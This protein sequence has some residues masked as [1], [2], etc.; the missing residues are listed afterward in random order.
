MYFLVMNPFFFLLLAAV[1]YRIVSSQCFQ[2]WWDGQ[3]GVV[4]K[5]LPVLF[6]ICFK[7]FYSIRKYL[8]VSWLVGV[9]L[10][11]W[12]FSELERGYFSLCILEQESGSLSLVELC[13]GCICPSV[14][15]KYVGTTGLCAC[16]LSSPH[17]QMGTTQT[18]HLSPVFH[19]QPLDKLVLS[20]SHGHRWFLLSRCT[21]ICP[22]VI[23]ISQCSGVLKTLNG[24]ERGQGEKNPTN[25]PWAVACSCFRQ[26]ILA[27]SLS[28]MCLGTAEDKKKNKFTSERTCLAYS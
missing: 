25:Q 8:G 20:G 26:P 4:R 15:C 19:F 18:F 16:L 12:G 9:V 10:F 17:S 24:E 14:C 1:C 3:W 27:A 2:A 5:H 28:L 7:I 11:V 22:C 23:Y 21:C 13:L 6:I